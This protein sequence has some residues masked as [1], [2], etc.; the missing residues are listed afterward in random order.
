MN[1]SIELNLNYFQ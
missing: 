1:F